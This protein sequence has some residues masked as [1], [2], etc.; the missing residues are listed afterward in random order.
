MYFICKIYLFLISV[1]KLFRVR[2]GGGAR[3]NVTKLLTNSE[4]GIHSVEAFAVMKMLY[5]IG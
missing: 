1:R 5:R 4:V 3:L 2:K